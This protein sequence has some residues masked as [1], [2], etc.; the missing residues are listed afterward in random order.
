MA[1]R[2]K[3]VPYNLCDLRLTADANI[4]GTKIKRTRLGIAT[5]IAQSEAVRAVRVAQGRSWVTNV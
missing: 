5:Q 3:T 1:E 2:K 4:Q